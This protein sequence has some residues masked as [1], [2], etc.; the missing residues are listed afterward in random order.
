MYRALDVFVG[1]NPE[2]ATGTSMME[3]AAMGLP[4]VAVES[5]AARTVIADGETGR[6]VSPSEVPD[7]LASLL[8]DPATRRDMGRRARA[9]AEQRFDRRHIDEQVLRVYERTLEEGLA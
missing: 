3:A 2:D 9:R 7:A 5:P 4:T 1:L 8:D 6:I